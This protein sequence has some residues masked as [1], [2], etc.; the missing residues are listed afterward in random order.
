MIKAAGLLT[1]LLLTDASGHTTIAPPPPAAREVEIIGRDYAFTAPIELTAGRTAFRF[2]NKG[3][4]IHELRV[5]LLMSG[6]TTQNVMAMLN[7]KQPLKPLIEA[8]VG[9][10]IARAGQR[11]S[12]R[13]ATDLLADRDYLVICSFQ[14]SAS[15]P[16]HSRMGMISV[17]H[18]LPG[19]AA[20]S[21]LPRADT[22]I[23]T[24]YAF[25]A[26]ST[27]APG[28]HTF[29]LV[30]AGTVNHEVNIALLRRGATAGQVFDIAK[31]NGR[32]NDLVD[33]WIGVLLTRTGTS[34]LGTLEVT[35]L[36]GREYVLMCQLSNDASAPSHLTLGM[37]GSVHAKIDTA[38]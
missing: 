29:V 10:L 23:G 14:D 30:N 35:L 16:M 32:L 36:P 15:A 31:V 7:A 24:D 28:P 12:T 8:P 3:K 18:V 34:S 2:T 33:E 22:I 25:R 11:S 6:T 26:P 4:V 5:A 19:H 9:I 38:Q 17:I 21:Q 37:F 20:P 1:A 27:L 13:L